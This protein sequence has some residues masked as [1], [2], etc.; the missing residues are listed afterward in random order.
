MTTDWTVNC[1]NYD[2]TYLENMH[3]AYLTDAGGR[4][5]ASET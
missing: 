4:I 3:A 5:Y 1:F 2:Q